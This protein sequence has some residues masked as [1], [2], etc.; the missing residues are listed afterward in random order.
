MFEP[1]KSTLKAFTLEQV[2]L[3]A[4]QHQVKKGSD[5]VGTLHFPYFVP[6]ENNH[7]GF[8]TAYDGS[9]E[10]YVQDFV[11]K[12]GRRFS[13]LSSNISVTRRQPQWRSIPRSSISGRSTTTV[14]LSDFYSAYPGL[15]VQDIRACS[16]TLKGYPLRPR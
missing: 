3:R 5:A 6:F 7:V 10:K 11:D 16:P 4:T 8:F 13:M 1:V 14:Q 2:V 12:V 15:G 9:F